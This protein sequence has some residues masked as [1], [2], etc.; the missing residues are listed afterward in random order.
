MWT[1]RTW[2]RATITV[3]FEPYSGISNIKIYKNGMYIW[4]VMSEIFLDFAPSYL[5]LGAD[6]NG[7]NGFTGFLYGLKVYTY[8]LPQVPIEGNTLNLC[9]ALAF[10][11]NTGCQDCPATC[12]TGCVRSSDCNLCND[13]LCA[14]C[15]D[16]TAYPC[17]HCILHASLS[18]GICA[19]DPGYY[20]SFSGFGVP[21]CLPCNPRCGLCSGPTD[22]ACSLCGAGEYLSGP[23]PSPCICP[24]G[25]YIDIPSGHC[26]PCRG[27]CET[28][29]QNGGCVTC[30]ANSSLLSSGCICDQG[31]YGSKESCLVCQSPC[32]ACSGR[33]ECTLCPEGYS[34]VS[35]ICLIPDF[36]CS[37]DV[38]NIK[39]RL[40]RLNFTST[41]ALPLETNDIKLEA[42]AGDE[43]VPLLCGWVF[44]LPTS[45]RLVPVK[46]LT[47]PY[48][49]ANS[50]HGTLIVTF[51][52]PSS[53]L[54]TEGGVLQT[55]VL[56]TPLD[57]EIGST[58]PNSVTPQVQA[59]VQA[60]ASVVLVTGL[61]TGGFGGL[62]GFFNTFELLT[63]LP[64]ANFPLTD[65]L[66]NVLLG[67]NVLDVMPNPFDY[68]EDPA[69]SEAET[70]PYIQEN[71]PNTSLFL[72]NISQFLIPIICGFFYSLSL[73]WAYQLPYHHHYIRKLWFGMRWNAV[74]R[75]LLQAYMTAT[76]AGLLQSKS[77]S[78]LL[79]SAYGCVN[80]LIGMLCAGLMGAAAVWLPWFLWM[81]RADIQKE[82][83]T[84]KEQYG[85]LVVE[86]DSK[87]GWG[88][89]G[90]YVPFLIRRL[91]YAAVLVFAFDYPYLQAGLIASSALIIFLH[92]S[93]Y[94]PHLSLYSLVSAGIQEFTTCSVMLLC[95]AFVLPLGK[96]ANRYISTLGVGLIVGGVVLS[97]LVGVM[98]ASV[99]VWKTWQEFREKRASRV[100]PKCVL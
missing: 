35:G 7:N 62:W 3:E 1:V 27:L 86:F 16:F 40:L 19:C 83:E 11:S 75:L 70:T 99:T 87:K 41:L 89:I 94:R 66:R 31:Y 72:P 47:I 100:R 74:L 45:N 12:S 63:Y 59:A 23:P 79:V 76:Y 34:L 36:Y 82:D 13:R 69:V 65:L 5:V 49:N 46:L 67:L 26:L 85:T 29:D 50:F 28:C 14:V 32:L 44:D 60:A 93:L 25:S 21:A 58:S 61:I 20:L 81:H 24:F 68:I 8:T 10:Q 97:A 56:E 98:E 39:N 64:L 2:A 91:L 96:A 15:R 42:K 30:K 53:I 43:T 92:F 78:L 54:D 88:A 51:I 73:L 37:L 57:W 38:L 55:K 80:V 22:S 71:G 33:L 48:D 18:F 9:P 77:P 84:F 17:L 52:N 6:L 95:C 90:T 4:Y